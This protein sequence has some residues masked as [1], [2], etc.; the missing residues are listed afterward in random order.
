DAGSTW[1]K[2]QEFGK[3]LD[4]LQKNHQKLQLAFEKKQVEVERVE[5]RIRNEEK[6][7]LTEACEKLIVQRNVSRAEMKILDYRLHELRSSFAITPECLR[8]AKRHVLEIQEK[9]LLISE[10]IKSKNCSLSEYLDCYKSTNEEISSLQIKVERLQKQISALMNPIRGADFAAFA[11]DNDDTLDEVEK[12]VEIAASEPERSSNISGFG[13]FREWVGSEVKDTRAK[14]VTGFQPESIFSR[15][16]GGP[17]K[18]Y[19]STEVDSKNRELD[20][21]TKTLEMLQEKIICIRSRATTMIRERDE[22]VERLKELQTSLSVAMEDV[23]TVEAQALE[24]YRVRKAELEQ[25]KE[26]ALK[27]LKESESKLRPMTERLEVLY[28]ITQTAVKRQL[29][30]KNEIQGLKTKLQESEL[31]IA[32]HQMVGERSLGEELNLT[33]NPIPV[34]ENRKL[35]IDD[36]Q[37]AVREAEEAL[38]D[39]ESQSLSL[40]VGSCLT[41]S[42]GPIEIPGLQILSEL[43]MSRE[44][45]T[46]TMADVLQHWIHVRREVILEE[47]RNWLK[48]CVKKRLTDRGLEKALDKCMEDR[49][50]ILDGL[51]GKIICDSRTTWCWPAPVEAMEATTQKLQKVLNSEVFEIFGH[52]MML[53]P[54]TSWSLVPSRRFSLKALQFRRSLRCYSTSSGGGGSKGPPWGLILGGSLTAGLSGTVAGAAFFPDF[55][56]AV[57]D[58]VPGSQSALDFMLGPLPKSPSVQKTDDAL[59]TIKKKKVESAKSD[60]AKS[61]PAVT[62][63]YRPV[64][65]PPVVTEKPTPSVPEKEKTSSE[66]SVNVIAPVVVTVVPEPPLIEPQTAT[67]SMTFGDDSAFGSSLQAP[68]PPSEKPKEDKST[69]TEPVDTPAPSANV[70]SSTSAP[71][72]PSLHGLT[73]QL[74]IAVEQRKS[75]P[76]VVEALLETEIKAEDSTAEEDNRFKEQLDRATYEEELNALRESMEEEMIA[77]LQRQ[78]SAYQQH[79]KEELRQQRE[80]LTEQ[81]DSILQ[82]KVGETKTAFHLELAKM[83]AELKGMHAG[84]EASIKRGRDTEIPWSERLTPLKERVEDIRKVARSTGSSTVTSFVDTALASLPSQAVA[85]GVYPQ[86]ALKDRFQDV[87]RNGRRVALIGDEGASLYKY[88]LSYMMSFLMLSKPSPASLRSQVVDPEYLNNV[89]ILDRAKFCLENDDLAQAVRYM[90]LLR[91]E[92]RRL[93]SDW[94]K[95]AVTLLETQLVADALLAF[96]ASSPRLST[97]TTK[98]DRSSSV[99]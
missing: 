4:V 42:V 77:Q 74:E 84:L 83:L 36:S 63:L 96:A 92:S 60:A 50:T 6:R 10:E 88:F 47:E 90:N 51:V 8:E 13:I 3:S 34:E 53:V 97:G 11:V 95:E 35:L 80:Q 18:T 21:S 54:K 30:L 43:I 57:Q 87:D 38:D 32:R 72:H 41:R 66:E 22:R 9:I 94:M 23:V 17:D 7:S 79:L 82:E 91:G 31:G 59:K 69:N 58:N 15:Q 25:K 26:E 45:S 24:F 19:R 73:P 5:S 16:K 71:V 98:Q 1:E 27:R 52:M 28:R 61:D 70:D 65:V 56:C 81:Y 75:A 99:S 67:E 20:K 48:Y 37:R 62:S 44:P 29:E 89:D 39:L 85:R 14:G 12:K 46:L 64:T 33:H 2:V 49:L 40:V 68:A 78:T 76:E 86:G 93:A 55:R